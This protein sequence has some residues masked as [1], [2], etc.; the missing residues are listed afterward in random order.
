M[1]AHDEPPHPDLCC[2]QIQLF[3]ARW[4]KSRKSYC[5]TPGI[6]VGVGVG[7]GVGGGVGI[8][9]MFKFL[10]LSFLCDGQGP[11]RQTFLSL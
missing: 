1:V 6:G 3:L 10:H 4:M 7:V 2:L 5:T 11:V 8:S 9:K